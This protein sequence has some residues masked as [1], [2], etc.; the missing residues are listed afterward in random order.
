[1]DKGAFAA[2]VGP[3]GSGKS[4][5]LNLIGCLDHPSAG[6]PDGARHRHRHARPQ[7]RGAPSAASTSASSSRTSTWCRCSPPT[8]TS[9]TRC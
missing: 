4:T 5:L 7:R 6:T 9:S 2:F 1:M 8:R 3:S